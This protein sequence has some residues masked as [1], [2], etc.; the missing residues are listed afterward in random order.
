MIFLDRDEEL[1]KG[2]A[3]YF[4]SGRIEKRN[5]KACDFTVNSLKALNS[6]FYRIFSTRF[7]IT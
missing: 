7:K 3:E 5:K 4:S 1:L 2:I 6:F